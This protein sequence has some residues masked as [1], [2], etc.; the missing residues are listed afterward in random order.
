VQ[1]SIK[2][3]GKRQ[4]DINLST[5]RNNTTFFYVKTYFE[6]QWNGDERR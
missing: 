2:L 6:L 1:T 3:R 5:G 4:A